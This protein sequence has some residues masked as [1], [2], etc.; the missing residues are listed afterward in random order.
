VEERT[1]NSVAGT[2]YERIATQRIVNLICFFTLFLVTLV[3]LSHT[4]AAS[5]F[6]FLILSA[7]QS[8]L[9]RHRVTFLE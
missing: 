3:F 7:T 8:P 2:G 5:V 6:L 4:S 9:H 1:T